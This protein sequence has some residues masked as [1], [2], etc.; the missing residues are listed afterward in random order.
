MTTS[1]QP[2]ILSKPEPFII[3]LQEASATPPTF[4]C[5]VGGA[6]EPQLSWTYIPNLS[7][8]ELTLR[9]GE[10]YN[11]TRNVTEEDNGRTVV[12]STI[13]FLSISNTDGGIVRCSTG[14]EAS[15]T[16]DTLLTILGMYACVDVADHEWYIDV[17]SSW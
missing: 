1:E 4:T 11:I 16:A 2:S 8:D 10:E 3:G 7:G 5:S 12:T 15:I 9:D 13:T 17:G 6:P 14:P